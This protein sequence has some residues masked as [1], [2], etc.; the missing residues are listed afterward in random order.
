MIV[1][2][3]ILHKYYLEIINKLNTKIIVEDITIINNL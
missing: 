1:C 3:V 2:K